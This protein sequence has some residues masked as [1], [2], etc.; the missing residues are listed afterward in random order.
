MR[1]RA[2]RW[3]LKTYQLFLHH[4]DPP[5]SERNVLGRAARLA[6]SLYLED[7]DVICTSLI[8]IVIVIVY[9]LVGALLEETIEV[10]AVDVISS[11]WLTNLASATCSHRLFSDRK[12]LLFFL[13]LIL[14]T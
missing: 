5:R 13:E 14:P 3:Y 11:L 2:G 8:V 6:R 12:L 9:L 7:L 10:A 1:V 4:Q